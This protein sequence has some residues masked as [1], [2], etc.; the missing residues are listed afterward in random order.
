MNAYKCINF[1]VQTDNKGLNVDEFNK[2]ISIVN[3]DNLLNDKLNNY[4]YYN[5]KISKINDKIMETLLID[6]NIDKNR[7]NIEQDGGSK[8]DE[9][10]Q[11]ETEIF[12]SLLNITITLLSR[13]SSVGFTSKPLS[14]REEIFFPT[15]AIGVISF[16]S[17]I[18]FT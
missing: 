7:I 18:D 6:T 13:K 10:A 11:K 3:D 15:A 12:K 9:E 14:M 5:N 4:I 16:G 2:V 8:E 17:E 1:S